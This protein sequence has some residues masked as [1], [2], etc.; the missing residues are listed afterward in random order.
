LRLHVEDETTS[1]VA[2]ANII[3]AILV[4]VLPVA[5]CIGAGMTVISLWE[6]FLNTRRP[7]LK[8]R[9]IQVSTEPGSLPH[10]ILETC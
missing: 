3:L 4:V 7:A 8:A 9:R 10:L 6:D 2:H 5:L 1:A